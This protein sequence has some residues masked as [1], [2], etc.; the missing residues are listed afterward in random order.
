MRKPSNLIPVALAAGLAMACDSSSET[1]VEPIERAQVAAA[2]APAEVDPT[3][4]PAA[5][6]SDQ[7]AAGEPDSELRA[8]L[9]GLNKKKAEEEAEAASQTEPEEEKA[10][11][12]RPRRRAARAQ[13]AGDDA[14]AAMAVGGGGLSDSEFQGT[15]NG[16]RGIQGCIA[17]NA[18]H[19]DD[20]S[21]ALQL[22]FEIAADGSVADCRV[23]DTS[24]AVAQAIA[25]C[26]ERKA[27][28]LRFP[29]FAGDQTTKVAKFVF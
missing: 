26:V 9:L 15:V 27:R 5:A 21:G 16:W 19:Y 4:A 22:S 29:T 3:P 20:R 8:Q 7:P 11:Q 23:L 18:G 6:V 17:Q 12:R 24:N 2:A 28:R 25:P 1:K 10:T 13:P 14:L